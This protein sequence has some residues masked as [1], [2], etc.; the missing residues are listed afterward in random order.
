M[1]A[2]GAAATVVAYRRCEPF[3]IWGMLGYFSGMEALQ[4][5]GYG[6]LDN[7]GTTANRT[8]TV[9]SY[10]HIVFQPIV[11]NLFALE[12]VPK[13]V[14]ARVRLWVLA[15][16]GA[17]SAVMLVQILPFEH[18]GSCRAGT[19][20]CGPAWCTVSGNWHI[21]WDVPY[22]GLFLP[23]ET[24]IGLHSGFPAYMVAVFLLPLVYGAWRF[25]IL[26][27]V[28]G[29]ILASLLTDDPNEMPA[30]WCLFSIAIILIAMSPAV[31]RSVSA[32]S[33]WGIPVSTAAK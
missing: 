1:V 12:L 26:N 10:L 24:M 25:V 29:P 11:I 6:V 32:Q 13:P 9:L 17:S 15:V 3:A 2:V 14:A 33:W 5:A 7:C 16:A 18:F 23:F 21:A 20:L 22:N 27:A 8:V 30:V 19:P 28:A 31:R 4:L